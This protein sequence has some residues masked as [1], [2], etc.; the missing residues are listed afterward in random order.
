MAALI[1]LQ[2]AVAVHAADDRAITVASAASVQEVVDTLAARC[3]RDP[4]GVR[5]R[6]NTGGSNL[7]ARQIEAGAQ[8]DLFISADLETV[9]RLATKR[10]IDSSS[11][12]PLATNRVV[13]IVPVDRVLSIRGPG[14]L[15]GPSV[16]RVAIADT[17]VPIGRY[18]EA[19]LR[20]CGLSAVL[21][22]RTARTD[23]VRA[24][25]AAV[26]AGAVDLGFV[27]ATDARLS[28]RVRVVWE[29]P[30][31]EIPPVVIAAGIP[32]GRDRPP[33]REFLDRLRGTEGRAV[34]ERAGFIAVDD[35]PR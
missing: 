5:V 12:V 28:D 14:D 11:I 6:V 15:A 27:Y 20:R 33:V 10:L 3:G 21:G 2:A 18:T 1:G 9:V 13:A 4:G 8:I 29:V 35:A 25:L 31:D 26:A 34:F 16:R 23:N 32:H 19:Y 24:T 30:P 7:L 17:S 22:P